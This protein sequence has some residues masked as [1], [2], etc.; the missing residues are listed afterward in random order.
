MSST[1]TLN[2]DGRFAAALDEM[3]E[4]SRMSKTAIIRQAIRL[5]Q[6]VHLRALNGEQLAFTKDGVV[7]PI[8]VIGLGDIG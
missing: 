5:Y 4:T 1:L 7:V 8:I 3:S 6:T 2:L